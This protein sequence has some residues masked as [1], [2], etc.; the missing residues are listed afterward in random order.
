MLI[1]TQLYLLFEGV[2]DD[3]HPLPLRSSFPSLHNVHPHHSFIHTFIFPL[4]VRTT[5]PPSVALHVCLFPGTSSY[6]PTIHQA[7]M[8]EVT[9][10]YYNTFAVSTF[11][12]LLPA[13]R[14][15]ASRC[16]ARA[17]VSRTSERRRSSSATGRAE[18]ATSSPTSSVSG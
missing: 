7:S 17:R 12:T 14:E 8:R 10:R 18:P 11:S 9:A 13:R 2:L 3:V 5:L 1:I 15:A 4:H 6:I 16:R